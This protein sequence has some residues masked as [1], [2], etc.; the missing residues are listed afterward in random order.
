MLVIR[1]SEDSDLSGEAGSPDRWKRLALLIR[2][3]VSISR[4][5]PSHLLL[6]PQALICGS[7]ATYQETPKYSIAASL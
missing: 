4:Q 2:M 7:D 1:T 6:F 5:L 3:R